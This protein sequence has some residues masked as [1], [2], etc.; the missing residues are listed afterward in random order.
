MTNTTGGKPPRKIPERQCMGCG[1][2]R[3]K[4]ELIRVLRTPEGAVELDLKGRK[5]GRGAY[6]CHNINCLRQARKKRRLERVLELP[7]PEEVYDRLE[8]ELTADT[9]G[10]PGTP[11]APTP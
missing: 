8:A 11:G 1:T 5:S 7:I 10:T 6:L 3:P 4:Q 2:R 9:P